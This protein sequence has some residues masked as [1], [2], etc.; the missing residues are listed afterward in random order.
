M[1][2]FI[3]Y[4]HDDHAML[5]RFR[6]HLVALEEAFGLTFWS[7]GSL[8]AGHH[9]NDTILDQ[10]NQ[11]EVFLLLVS[12]S[13]IASKFIREREIPAIEQRCKAVNGLILPVVLLPSAWEGVV[14]TRQA[15][16]TVRSRLLPV[17]QWDRDDHAYDAARIQLH[18]AIRDHFHRTDPRNPDT[19]ALVGY[20]DPLVTERNDQLD[21]EREGDAADLAAARHPITRQL[22]AA[23]LAKAQDLVAMLKETLK[24]SYATRGRL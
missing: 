5:E 14:G 17:S 4:A 3:S 13:F 16:P 12:P 11:A 21:V 10:I 8:R 19:D 18:A 20:T 23:N 9:W 2:G 15:A 22:H 1:L 24:K 7:D 6:V